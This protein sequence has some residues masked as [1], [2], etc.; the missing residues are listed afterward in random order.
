MLNKN[1]NNRITI[2]EVFY[3]PWLRT[4]ANDL[5]PDRVLANKLLKNLIAFKSSN[6]LI[7]CTLAFLAH[8]F[9]PNEELKDIRKLFENLDKNGDG[10]LSKEEIYNGLSEYGID[11]FISPDE[12]FEN[13]DLDQNGFIDY[14]EFLTGVISKNL[15]TSKNN[16][17]VAFKALDKDG[18]GTISTSEL[19]FALNG[20]SS[21]E[22]I[23]K[24]LAEIDSN[25]DGEID[26]EEFTQAVLKAGFSQQL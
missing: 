10:R 15:E 19:I 8:C 17:L 6:K 5:V 25:G 18:N 23:L 16:L 13:C 3:D 9:T 12:I 1:P 22:N 7:T 2:G 24:L 11:I 20:T 21:E 4:R 26:L 14:S